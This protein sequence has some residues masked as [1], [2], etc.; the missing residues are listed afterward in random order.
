LID[1]FELPTGTKLYT[2]LP[3]AQRQWV[4]LTDEKIKQLADKHL[5]VGDGERGTHYV[6]GEIEFARAIE[7]E[8]KELNT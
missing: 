3:A 5:D 7:A 6:F 8:L 1:P 2:T 4:G